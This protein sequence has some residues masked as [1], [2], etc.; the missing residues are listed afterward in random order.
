MILDSTTFA[1]QNIENPIS[2]KLRYKICFLR[3]E[4]SLLFSIYIL[5]AMNDD[6]MRDKR[7]GKTKIASSLVGI[8]GS[9]QRELEIPLAP[10]K[11]L[12][13]ISSI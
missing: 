3:G 5:N 13:A 7:A 10:S 1:I 9:T 6:P 4:R 11:N 8:L 2:T 12:V